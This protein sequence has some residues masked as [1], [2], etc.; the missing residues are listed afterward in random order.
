MKR[1]IF[2]TI[3]SLFI[4]TGSFAQTVNLVTMK[5]TSTKPVSIA[6]QYDAIGEYTIEVNGVSM[7]FISATNGISAD[8]E[9]IITIVATENVMLT[10]L[11]VGSI[12]LTELDV[13]NSTELT[14]L[15][16]PNNSLTELNVTN[17]TALRRIACYSNSL[18]E[19]NVT[20][21]TELTTLWC[22]NN[23]I[24]SLDISNNPHITDL[25]AHNQAITVVVPEGATEFINPIFYH[26]QTEIEEVQIDGVAYAFGASVPMPAEG[27][28]VSF[29][30]NV[31]TTDAY[32]QPFG[33]VITFVVEDNS[34]IKN[35]SLSA[36]VYSNGNGT[37]TVD[38]ANSETFNVTVINMQGQIV[39]TETAQGGS[40]IVNI[41]NQPAGVYMF[42]IDDG[43]QKATVK[44]K[45]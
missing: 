24:S 42:V 40:H 37:F 41:I 17:N 18:T 43:K 33:G 34:S 32:S 9:G 10:R 44:V 16:C 15:D 20:N 31:T 12:E 23:Q 38:V 39:K 22:E 8:D 1:I 27:N 6:V 2:T 3:I 45:R 7:N 29:V 5:T 25:S 21:N 13:T 26:N 19:L 30:T 28:S 14:R 35:N 11:G 36:E 4:T